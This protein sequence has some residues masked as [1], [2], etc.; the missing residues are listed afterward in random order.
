MPTSSFVDSAPD[1]K[2]MKIL[3]TRPQAQSAGL[4][5]ALVRRGANVRS[6]PLLVIAPLV[7]TPALRQM[8]MNID[9][10]DRVIFISPNAA[11]LGAELIDQFWPQLPGHIVWIA[12]GQAT[13]EALM[14][15]G[16]D[17]Q[18]PAATADSEGLLEMS[19]LTHCQ[20]QSILIV[21]GRGGRDLLAGTLVRRGASISLAEVY[22]RLCPEHP[23]ELVAEQLLTFNPDAIVLYSGET[24]QNLLALSDK[25]GI[26]VRN[27]LILVPG[28]RVAEQA[29][30]NHFEKILV[31]PSLKERDVV[32][33]L[34]TWWQAHS[35]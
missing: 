9:R 11:A 24:L 20:G 35:G 13:A 7:Q 30:T 10:F 6:L 14:R 19:A 31:P 17:A 28:E 21:R 26:P 18:V 5:A 25:A 8:F 16:I 27:R 2:D 33:T 23:N 22:E 12:V 34:R 32:H 3:L 1:L 29:R 4:L 15:F